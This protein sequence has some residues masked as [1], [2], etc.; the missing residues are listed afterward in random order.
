MRT[1]FT[2]TILSFTLFALSLFGIGR[3]VWVARVFE[4][5]PP[6]FDVSATVYFFSYAFAHTEPLVQTLLFVALVSVCS[7]TAFV[8]KLL[9]SFRGI[10]PSSL[11][12]N[13]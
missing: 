9:S 4:N 7:L 12:A 5:I 10:T 8:Q 1:F 6:L 2:P 11:R 3:E 13:S